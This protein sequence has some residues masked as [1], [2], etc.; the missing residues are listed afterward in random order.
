MLAMSNTSDYR[1]DLTRR[2]RRLRQTAG[3][4]ALVGET[5]VQARQLIQPLFVIDG[6]GKAEPIKSMP[7]A[8]PVQI[9][10]RI[11]SIS[12][13]TTSTESSKTGER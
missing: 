4:R 8:V 7:S 10:K 2:P 3:V 9:S 1:L 12:L 6:K 5:E 13:P 11:F